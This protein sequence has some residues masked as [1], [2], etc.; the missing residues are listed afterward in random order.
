MGNCQNAPRPYELG[1]QN[2]WASSKVGSWVTN[3]IYYIEIPIRVK[4]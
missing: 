1:V 4:K 3:K 2:E